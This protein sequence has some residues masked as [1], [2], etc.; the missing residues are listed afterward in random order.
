MQAI[1]GAINAYYSAHNAM[2]FPFAGVRA[3]DFTFGDGA[4]DPYGTDGP[5]LDTPGVP[6][7]DTR[8]NSSLIAILMNRGATTNLGNIVARR[9][10]QKTVFLQAQSA[11]DPKYPNS[12]G[13]GLDGVYRD[14][15]GMPYM[16]SLDMNNDNRV[17]DGLYSERADAAAVGL[18]QIDAN[19]GKYELVGRVMVWSMGPDKT[20]DKGQLAM[21]DP[22]LPAAQRVNR[23]NILSWK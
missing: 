10:P 16:I 22:S 15:W 3:N 23:D 18:T 4:L 5:T 7:N 6:F 9:N 19:P 14:P 20:Y 21:P 12:P 13:V 2:P 8:D 17:R 11:S 1:V